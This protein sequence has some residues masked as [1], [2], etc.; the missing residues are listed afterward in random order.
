[1]FVVFSST[2]IFGGIFL[3]I[4]SVPIL[5]PIFFH[6]SFLGLG[7]LAICS[8]Y[9]STKIYV[10]CRNLLNEFVKKAYWFSINRAIFFV[11]VANA[12]TFTLETA[13]NS[14]QSKSLK[15]FN[16]CNNINY[17]INSTDGRKNFINENRETC[18]YILWTC[19]ILGFLHLLIGRHR[20]SLILN[21]VGYVC[22]LLNKFP[23]RLTPPSVLK[24]F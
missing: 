8:E 7:V 20:N 10:P 16:N 18:V 21:C 15:P 14:H 2:G 6:V 23:F 17:I 3:A 5:L 4:I 13:L 22:V 24:M 9:F 1:M 11:T 19:C 12:L